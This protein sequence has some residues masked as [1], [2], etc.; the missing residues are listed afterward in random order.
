MHIEKF[1]EGLPEHPETERICILTDIN[2][3]GRTSKR[4]TIQI[5][6]QAMRI[7]HQ[8]LIRYLRSLRIRSPCAL[9]ALPR[10][11]PR[12]N[13]EMH[14]ENRF[15]YLID[16]KSAYS[17]VDGRRLANI[18][19]RIDNTLGSKDEL[20]DFLWN[21]CLTNSGGLITG[22][23]ASPDLFNLYAGFVLDEPLLELWQKYNFTYTRYLDDLTFSSE[24]KI[25]KIKRKRIRE[26][27]ERVGFRINYR[28]SKVLDLMKGPIFINGVGLEFGGRIFLPRHFL[29]R[30]SGQIYLAQRNPEMRNL[31]S[32]S[33][34]VFLDISDRY[35]LNK[36]EQKLIKKYRKLCS[37]S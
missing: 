36:T 33:M 30:L 31:V 26:V 12:K 17:S 10:T 14:R 34:G 23:P 37:A 20:Y 21:Y 9:G 1:L 27:I 28:K 3:L 7:V 4:R 11:S 6:N 22:F 16:L 29:R 8:R 2:P 13:T 15:F 18:L 19:H 35:R 25:G 5:P 32:G 24:E